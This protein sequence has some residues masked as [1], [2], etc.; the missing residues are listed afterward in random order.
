MEADLNIMIIESDPYISEGL[1]EKVNHLGFS[2][3]CNASPGRPIDQLDAL[4]PELAILGPSLEEQTCLE[5]LHKLKIID[6]FMP[7]LTSSEEN[8]LSEIST[9]LLKGYIL[10]V[11]ISIRTKFRG[12]LGRH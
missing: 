9:P 1:K 3:S 10:S 5:C 12:L 11:R 4:N 2:R 6:P 7:V 8:C